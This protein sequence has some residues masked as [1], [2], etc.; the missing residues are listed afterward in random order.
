M[1]GVWPRL[2]WQNLTEYNLMIE[3]WDINSFHQL[4]PD[5]NCYCYFL[6]GYNKQEEV[7]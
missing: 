4:K 6:V 2:E 1:Y 3:N 5:L 7:D